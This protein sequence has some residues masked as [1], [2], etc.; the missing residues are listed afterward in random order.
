MRRGKKRR[1]A[2]VWTAVV[3]EAVVEEEDGRRWVDFEVGDRSEA[4]FLKLYDRL[5]EAQRYVNMLTGY[6]TG[7]PGTG[8]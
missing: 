4:T 8:T 1:E 2:W 3:E 6:M 5:P 7:C